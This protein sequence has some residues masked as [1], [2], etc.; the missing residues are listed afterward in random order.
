MKLVHYSSICEEQYTAYISEWESNQETPTPS[1]TKRNGVSFT[2]K[3]QQWKDN[4]TDI[5]IKQGYVSSMLYF[6]ISEDIIMG[7][8][9]YRPEINERL[10]K[11]GGH[12]G[13]GI[14]PSERRKGYATLMLRMLLDNIKREGAVK[15]ML[16][17]DD[18]NIASAKTIEKNHGK[19]YEKAIFENILIRKYWID[20]KN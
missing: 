4:E 16:T 5:P 11:C 12:I 20:L 18:D 14:R 3:Y 9:V 17:C 19:L 10:M 13:Y 1:A 6:L 2:E 8:I 7:S 15:V